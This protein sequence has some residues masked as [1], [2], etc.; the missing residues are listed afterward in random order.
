MKEFY[1][2]D[3]QTEQGPYTFEQLKSLGIKRETLIWYEGAEWT[4]AGTVPELKELFAVR[5]IPPPLTKTINESLAGSYM[6]VAAAEPPRKEKKK[7]YSPYLMLIA[8][9]AG[10][11]V[12]W[13]IYQNSRNNETISTLQTQQTLNRLKEDEQKQ[14]QEQTEKKNLNY[15]NNWDKY[16]KMSNSQPSIDYALGGI[17]QFNVSVSNETEYMLDQ[18]DVLV[19]YIRKNGEVWQSRTVSFNNVAP[20]TIETKIAPSS[21][22]GVRVNLTIQKIISKKMQF[23]YPGNN[24]NEND[25]YFCN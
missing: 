3:G 23:C 16:I 6:H 17:S 1:I 20:N 12:I 19:E 25:P 10:A 21:I 24:S 5:P 18:V 13:L 15:R 22:N 8:I 7:S 2:H 14:I 11:V 4:Q 9:V